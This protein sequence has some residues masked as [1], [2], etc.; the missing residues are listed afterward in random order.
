MLF[1]RRIRNVQLL[2]DDLISSPLPRW[3]HACLAGSMGRVWFYMD[4]K[5][6]VKERAKVAGH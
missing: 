5:G 6:P 1:H 4:A 2:N 3:A